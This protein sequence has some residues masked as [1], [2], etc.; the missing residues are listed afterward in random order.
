[1]KPWTNRDEAWL[2]RAYERGASDRE[3]AIGLGRGLASVRERR[4]HLGLIRRV[5]PVLRPAPEEYPVLVWVAW[6]LAERRREGGG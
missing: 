1:M 4:R 5:A 6:R 3:M 2:R